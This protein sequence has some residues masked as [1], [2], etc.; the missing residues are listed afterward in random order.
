MNN[1]MVCVTKQKTCQRLIDFGSNLRKEKEDQLFVIHVTKPDYDFLDHVEEG[2]A[3]EFLYEKAKEADASL[4][5]ERSD[6]AIDTLTTIAKKNQITHV[7]VGQSGEK[8][9]SEG[10]LMQLEQALG[11]KAELV[12]VP[13]VS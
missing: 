4:M 3:L 8:E 11:E 6:R 10:F 12:V 2:E 1:I 13:A 9:A 7:V 5:V